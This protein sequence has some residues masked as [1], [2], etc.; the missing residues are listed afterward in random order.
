MAIDL[1]IVSDTSL[2]ELLF[3]KEKSKDAKRMFE[4]RDWPSINGKI[5]I[6]PFDAEHLGPFSYDLCVGE[7]V[8]NLE[9]RQKISMSEV[10]K[11]FVEPNEILLILT[12]EYIGLPREFA[13]SV[14]PRFCFVRE[15]IFQS[16]TKIDP[17]WFGRI[18]VAIINYSK[19]RF[20]LNKNQA[21]CT[22]V[23]HRLD[24]PSSKILNPKDSPALG[25]ETIEQFLMK[26]NNSLAI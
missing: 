13:A 3:P 5:L 23:I 26:K 24:K 15:G 22:L 2:K 19:T 10:Q 14:V 21:F 11:I 16:M 25:K 7:E 1:C 17:T 8:F 9:K 12:R 4:K 18:A 6:Y 20:K